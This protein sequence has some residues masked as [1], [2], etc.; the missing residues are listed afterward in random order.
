MYL[1]VCMM[2]DRKTIPLYRLPSIV[3]IGRITA[4]L[5]THSHKM[6]PFDALGKQAF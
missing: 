3:E 4:C 6:T 2:R 1:H 5:L